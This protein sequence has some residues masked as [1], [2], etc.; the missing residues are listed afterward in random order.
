[1]E[2]GTVPETIEARKNAQKLIENGSMG[3]PNSTLLLAGSS[4]HG[5][6]GPSGCHNGLFPL[7]A[8]ILLL[9]GLLK[10]LQLI[11]ALSILDPGFSAHALKPILQ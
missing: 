7:H 1:M 3:Q 6:R 2:T 10:L 8:R 9:P 4:I 11:W 5:L